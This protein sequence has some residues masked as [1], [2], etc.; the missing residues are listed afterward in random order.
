MAD[1]AAA[2]IGGLAGGFC[3]AALC[4]ACIRA[5]RRKAKLNE[6]RHLAQIEHIF[7]GGDDLA[8]GATYRDSQLSNDDVEL[9]AADLQQLQQLQLELKHQAVST[10]TGG[11][12]SAAVVNAAKA[13]RAALP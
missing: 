3:L 13:S 5:R 4:F 10:G 2:A 11:G 8:P 1:T 12:R 9:T 6:H 7:E